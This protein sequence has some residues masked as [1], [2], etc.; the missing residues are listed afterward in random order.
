[1]DNGEVFVQSLRNRMRAMNILWERAVSDMTLEQVNHHERE[2]VLPM[3]F[4]FSH[5]MRAQDQTVS[6]IFR[7]EP[8]LWMSGGWAAKIGVSVDALGREESV[9]EMEVLRFGDLNAWKDFQSQVIVRTT[10][11]LDGMTVDGALEVVLPQLPPQMH[12]IFCAIVIGTE[13]PLRKLDAM[14]CFVYQ[15]GLRHMG[16]VEHGRALVGLQGMTS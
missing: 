14:E 12:N 8:P 16:E 11:V 2:G 15:H 9:E 6:M 3:A 13:A 4:S 10:E 1:M 5:F 7:R